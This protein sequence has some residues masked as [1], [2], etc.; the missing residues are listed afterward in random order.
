M[1]RTP[2]SYA[3]GNGHESVVKLLLETENVDVDCKDLTTGRTA[4]SYAAE[5]GS[6]IVVEDLLS[7]GKANVDSRDRTGRKPLRWAIEEGREEVAKLLRDK[8]YR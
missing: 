2:L 1:Y 5:K 6:L 3:A 8:M 7:T 4:L